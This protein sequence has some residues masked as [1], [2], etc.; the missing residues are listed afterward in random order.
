MLGS[1]TLPNI[2]SFNMEPE[3]DIPPDQQHL[4]FAGKQLKDRDALSEQYSEGVYPLPAISI[5]IQGIPYPIPALPEAA[6]AY[7]KTSR[8]PP[9]PWW[10]QVVVNVAVLEC[11]IMTYV[12]MLWLY[13]A[14]Y[15]KS[16]LWA[17]GEDEAARIYEK[18]G[19]R[20]DASGSR[21]D[22][23]R[24]LR[25]LW[26]WSLKATSPNKEKPRDRLTLRITD[27]K[28]PAG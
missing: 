23:S 21:N 6:P 13:F 20:K 18:N 17:N 22:G 28:Q 3:E 8:G 26:K 27:G 19:R 15:Q 11:Y 10:L 5:P 12:D 25:E 9:S 7:G 1:T 2:L 16:E 24:G 14:A 4:I